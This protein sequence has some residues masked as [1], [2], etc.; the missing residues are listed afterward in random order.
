MGFKEIFD[1]EPFPGKIALS[2][3]NSYSGIVIKTPGTTLI[4]DP[5]G[6]SVEECVQADLI[7]V[8][9]EHSDHFNSR[10]VKELGKK[11]DAT[12]LTTPFVAKRLPEE[13]TRVLKVGDSY[14]V[15][16]VEVH[17]ERCDHPANQPLSFII[18]TING[19]TVY[20]PSDSDPFWEMSELV[21]KYKPN[22][23]L[24]VGVSPNNVAQMAK[25]IKPQVLVSLNTDGE[26]Q[27]KFARALEREAPETQIKMI[28][29]F[30][31]YQYP[32]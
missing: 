27:R 15:K 30:E 32:D 19:I 22:V 6:V 17:A 2:W 4:F 11:T 9:H 31:I 16:D 1:L 12:I 23:L 21:G 26:S 28:K 13:K 20:H 24:Y 10:L 18:S 3:F 25:L 29:R 8:T 5:V 7:V 14:A